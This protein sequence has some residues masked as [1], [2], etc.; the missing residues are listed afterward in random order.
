MSD[1]SRI[2][3]SIHRSMCGAAQATVTSQY[4]GTSAMHPTPDSLSVLQP[5]SRHNISIHATEQ[6]YMHNTN[7]MALCA[8]HINKIVALQHPA[9][10]A[11]ATSPHK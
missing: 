10:C 1:S 8:K 4:C 9:C 3:E 5:N 2:S 7:H 6:G 11:N